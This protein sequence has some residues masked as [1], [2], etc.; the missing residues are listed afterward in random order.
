M[1]RSPRTV[2][3]AADLLL[4]AGTTAD[5]GALS[6][7]FEPAARTVAARAAG[8]GDA[9]AEGRARLALAEAYLA[10]GR[11]DEAEAAARRAEEL[12]GRCGD[13]LTRF[14]APYARGLIALH[15]ARHGTTERHLTS[16]WEQCGRRG[17]A[18]GE[19]LVLGAL[20]RLWAATGN[21]YEAVLFAERSVGLHRD[22]AAG[23]PRLAHGHYAHAVALSS[24]GRPAGALRE[25]SRALPLFEADRQRLWAGRTRCRMAEAMVA[26]VRPAEAVTAAEDAAESLLVPGGERWRADALTAGGHA[27]TALGRKQGARANWREALAVLEDFAAPQTAELRTLLREKP[28]PSPAGP[29]R[30]GLS[31]AAETA[32]TGTALRDLTAAVRTLSDQ[33]RLRLRPPAEE[34]TGPRT[35]DPATSPD[36]LDALDALAAELDGHVREMER[37]GRT[38]RAG[39]SRLRA[40]LESLTASDALTAAEAGAAEMLAALRTLSRRLGP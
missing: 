5:C 10:L 13:A 26:L 28:D 36:A 20:A 34:G 17:D 30:P 21:S 35:A 33:L 39:L 37:T 12:A 32:R 23:S 3:T 15:Q 22:A 27:R 11:A 16:A 38:P 1:L 9:R 18:L 8:A 14:R 7:A 31:R 40:A 4:L 24:A 6:A 25:L 19:A 2:R 29:H